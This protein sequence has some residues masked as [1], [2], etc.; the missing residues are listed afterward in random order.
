MLKC[1]IHGCKISKPMDDEWPECEFCE[2]LKR[3]QEE[4]ET[5]GDTSPNE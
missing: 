4:A 1:P 3:K 5:D 2:E